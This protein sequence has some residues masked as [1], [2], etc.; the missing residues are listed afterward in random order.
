MGMYGHVGL[1][2]AMY[3]YHIMLRMA[4]MAMHGY[5]W[6]CSAMYGCVGPWMA[7][8]RCLKFGRDMLLACSAFK[9]D[10]GYPS[11]WSQPTGLKNR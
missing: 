5:A 2:S 7:M 11:K 1:C 8:K 6:V 4:S 9:L 10:S 3:S